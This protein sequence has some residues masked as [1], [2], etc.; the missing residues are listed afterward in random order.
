MQSAERL[1]REHDR[2]AKKYA[3]P[4]RYIMGESWLS[5][6][7]S[8]GAVGGLQRNGCRRQCKG[9]MGALAEWI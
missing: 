4:E 5:N 2:L 8:F 7:T 9:G 1:E 6:L 3:E